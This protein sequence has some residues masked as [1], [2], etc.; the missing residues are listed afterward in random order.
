[1]LKQK[2]IY[3]W[4]EVQKLKDLGLNISQTSK[5]TDL[6][7]TTVRKY[8]SLSEDEFLNWIKEPRRLPQKLACYRRFIKD[9][10]IKQNYLSASQVED[11]LKESFPDLPNIHSKTVYNFVNS[12]R[13]QYDIPKPSKSTSRQFEKLP[14]LPYGIQAQV[15]FGETTLTTSTGGRKKVYFFAIVL[16]RSRFK[17]IYFTEKPFTSHVA[18][19]THHKAFEYFQG[20]PS[21]ILYDQDKVFIHNENLGDYLL[22][23][24]F[25]T[26]CKSQD[27]R[28]V[29]CRKSDPQSKGKVEN[30]V[31]Y[32]KQNF[33]RGREFKNIERLNEEALMWLDRTGNAKIHSA[34]RLI[35]TKE[36]EIEKAYLLPLKQTHKAN[37]FVS[38]NVR[39]DNTFC[40]KSNFYSLPLGTYKNKDSKILICFDYEYLNIYKDENTLI[41]THK[42]SLSKG[43]TIRN[44]DH[45]REKSQSLEQ[46]RTDVLKLFGNTEESVLYIT[47][48]HKDKSRYFRD[49]L[50]HII[51]NYKTYSDEVKKQSLL[52]C[53]EN[54]IYNASALIKILDKNQKEIK[55]HLTKRFTPI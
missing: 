34:T 27:F 39:K 26:F 29:F 47:K 37:K 53:I 40:Y 36:W 52:F 12:I 7:R 49:N 6:D 42:I 22:T 18:S 30:V 54:N 41:C 1:M 11:R 13:K 24:D 21:E 43:Q 33:L 38:Y 2:K 50:L 16:S 35:P 20:V 3:M 48:L 28:H 44:T 31:K 25:S 23:K 5:E 45:K 15:D 9:L 46:Y 10:L 17:Y 51:K 55:Y 8:R 4:Y 32:V 19:E 14:E